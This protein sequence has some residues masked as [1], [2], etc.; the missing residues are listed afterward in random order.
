[1]HFFF[2]QLYKNMK[3][4]M[5][6]VQKCR[7]EGTIQPHETHGFA[8]T[9]ERLQMYKEQNQKFRKELTSELDAGLGNPC[10]EVTR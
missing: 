2:R 10:L 1:M 9:K 4:S 6:Y 3:E 7:E 5:K 8:W